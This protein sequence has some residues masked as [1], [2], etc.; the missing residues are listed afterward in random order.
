MVDVILT[1]E[2]L[3]ELFNYNPESGVFTRLVGTSSNAR[4][5]DISGW[6]KGQGYLVIS[7]GRQTIKAH[8][9]AFLYMTGAWPKNQTD[10]INGIK[11]DNRWVNLRDI[12]SQENTH[13]QRR[14]HKNSTTGFLGVKRRKNRFEA[15][16][17]I[18][19]TYIYLGLFDTPELAHDVYVK[20]KLELH[21]SCTL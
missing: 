4:V 14:A 3:K 16:I 13:N 21:S 18:N 20:A 8:R 19:G 12:T 11:A 2:R 1:Q 6:D 7:I 17:R 10:H 15:G 5:G 9:L